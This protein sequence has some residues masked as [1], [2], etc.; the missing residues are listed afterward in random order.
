MVWHALLMGIWKVYA[1][2]SMGGSVYS[3]ST[4][5]TQSWGYKTAARVR[6][7]H[8]VLGKIVKRD[9]RMHT[10]VNTVSVW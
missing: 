4:G 5:T 2:Y 7:C 9:I 1:R 10:F 6:L 8:P 3:L